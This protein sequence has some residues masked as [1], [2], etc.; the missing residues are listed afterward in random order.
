MLK[1]ETSRNTPEVVKMLFAAN[2]YPHN[3]KGAEL[4]M[5]MSIQKLI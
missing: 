4:H 2:I 3:S 5:D 1:V